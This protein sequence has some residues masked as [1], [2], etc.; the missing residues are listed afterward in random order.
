MEK[1][2]SEVATLLLRIG[3][4][5]HRAMAAAYDPALSPADRHACILD[6]MQQ[7]GD[8]RAAMVVAI[9][10]E[11]TTPLIRAATQGEVLDDR[12]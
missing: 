10:E 12:K 6:G 8:A 3:D 5:Y 7:I 11:A 2:P 1:E 9:G 4:A